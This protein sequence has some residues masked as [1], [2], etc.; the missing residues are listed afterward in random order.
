MDDAFALHAFLAKTPFFGGLP[1]ASM[2]FIEPMLQERAVPAGAVVVTEGEC[3]RSMYIVRHGTLHVVRRG[4]AGNLVKL[5]L[6]GDGDFF[7]VSALVEMEPRPFSVVAA[8][9]SVL[10]ELTSGDLYK[11]YRQDLKAYSLVVM[12][13][14][15]EL[16]RH[17]RRAGALIGQLM[18]APGAPKVT[19]RKPDPCSE[20]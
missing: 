14:N 16:C 11:L 2:E 8:R 6:L 19:S 10:L 17:L 1:E 13:I 9:D 4:S 5:Q 7:G 18:D 12:N 20:P 3:G 15:R